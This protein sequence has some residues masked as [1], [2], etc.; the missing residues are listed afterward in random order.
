MSNA[1][2]GRDLLKSCCTWQWSA[3]AA[4]AAAPLH[5]PL[6]PHPRL[7]NARGMG[8]DA[9]ARA[10]DQQLPSDLSL[11]RFSVEEAGKSQRKKTK[12]QLLNIS[13]R[14]SGK[15]TLMQN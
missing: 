12:E 15:A 2:D 4:A 6:P 14:T 10:A 11:Q 9:A 8:G 3:A 1:K 7:V 13:G 5:F